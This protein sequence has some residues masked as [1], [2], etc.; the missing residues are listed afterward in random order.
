MYEVIRQSIIEKPDHPHRWLLRAGNERPSRI[1]HHW[2]V[3]LL[4]STLRTII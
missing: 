1:V 3:I 4:P 2:R